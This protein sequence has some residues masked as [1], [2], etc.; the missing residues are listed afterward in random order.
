ME[1]IV[2]K[3]TNMIWAKKKKKIEMNALSLRYLV[4]NEK[5]R[6]ND[7]RCRYW[8]KYTES[9]CKNKKNKNWKKENYKFAKN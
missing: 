6:I 7:I 4:N 1:L 9:I 8:S 5:C 3:S 2:E